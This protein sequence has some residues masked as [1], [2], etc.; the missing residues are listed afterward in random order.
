MEQLWLHDTLPDRSSDWEDQ[1]SKIWPNFK[2]LVVVESY[3]S[4]AARFATTLIICLLSSLNHGHKLEYIDLDL[5]W[6]PNPDA[7]AME[8]LTTDPGPAISEVWNMTGTVLDPQDN[9]RNEYHNLRA[10][11]LANAALDPASLQQVAAGQ[12]AA[13]RLETLD[14][15]FP[16]ESFDTPAGAVSAAHLAKYEWL[17][18]AP[19]ITCMSL[20]QFRFREFPR[21]PEDMPLPTFLATFPKLETLEIRSD[22]YEGAELGAVIAAILKETK[23]LKLIYQNQI[24]GTVMD[25]LKKAAAKQGVQVV[26]GERPREWPVPVTP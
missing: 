23:T 7:V 18:G 22:H 2:S 20:S 5:P 24:R 25:Q 4:T 1:W 14:I 16:P 13:G 11:R 15:V 12:A 17:A 26:F 10:I 19:G 6:S 9:W 3:S 8:P 21:T